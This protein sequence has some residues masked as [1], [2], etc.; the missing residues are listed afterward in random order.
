MKTM[1]KIIVFLLT[2]ILS[3]FGFACGREN[4]A[5]NKPGGGTSLPGLAD[6]PELDDDPTN[7]FTVRLRLNG[8][9]Y[10]PT[11]A[12]NVYW[13][14]GYNIHIAPIDEDGV[15]TV[16]GLDGDYTVT[17]SAAPSG[18][19]YDPNA[20]MATND[21]RNIIIDMYD[22]GSVNAKESNLYN[23]HRIS[24][25]GVY[26]VTITE[27][28]DDVN[29]DEKYVDVAYFEFAPTVNGIYT[30]ESWVN[31]ADDDVNPV[32]LAY[33]G[34]FAYKH[35]EYRVTE[36]GTCGSYTR[37]FIH[38][39][40]IA[41]ENI[42]ANGS[43]SFSFG[44]TAETKSGIYPATFSF[45]IKRNGGFDYNR[46]TKTTVAPKFDWSDFDFAAFDALA[47]SKKVGA[48]TLY[49]GSEDSYVF[50]EYDYA[51]NKY[52][53]KV[54]EKAD[55]GDG[56]YHVY[57]EVKYASTGGYGPILF[58][59]ID[60]PCAYLEVALTHIEDAGNNA[61]VV[62]GGTE[63]YRQFIKG[64]AA[65]ADKGYYCTF[66]CTCHD[67]GSPLACLA[68]CPTCTPH[69]QPC[70]EELMG[71]KGYAELCNADGVAPVT[72]ELKEFLQK[73]SI[74]GGYF[75]DGEGHVDS[76]GVYA[77]EDSQWLFACGYYE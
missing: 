43:Q 24:T 21:N 76:R 25:T 69:C 1:K 44:I 10:I 34:S 12:V 62:N 53:Y 74:Q 41:D 33:L 66:N 40:Q 56:I 55:G 20:Y 5:I 37:N 16:D 9:A 71:K 15:A 57:D 49:P 61:L 6:Q 36:V 72:P 52:N 28:P 73:F 2:A 11:V 31:T 77:Y 39:V 38:T 60:K 29:Q 64:F 68:G 8:E 70:P 32:C 67:D 63:N 46:P 13:N 54:W 22:S 26:T 4:A 50:A 18:Y 27:D 45:A 65:V 42:G 75:A 23:A 30:V 58:A 7:D 35:G 47:G 19:A 48:Q 59:Y 3:L 14:D 51:L 17:L